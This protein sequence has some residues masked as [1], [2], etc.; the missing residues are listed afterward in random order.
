MGEAAPP[1]AGPH[2]RWLPT[3]VALGGITAAPAALA[4][5]IG[6]P[7]VAGLPVLA[8]TA[9]LSFAVQ[10]AAFVPSF[11]AQT[12]RF[13]DLTG[14]ATYVA[15]VAVCLAAGAAR[16]TLSPASWVVA[17]MVLAWSLRLGVFLFRRVHRD[18]GDRRF[19]AIKP[20]APR[21][22]T[23]WTLQGLWVWLTSLAAQVLILT[24]PGLGWAVG[25]GA[26]LWAVG[27]ALE[28]VADR[29]K[30][31][32]RTRP[33]RGPFIDSGLWAWSRHPNY[34]GEILLWAGVFVVGLGHWQGALWLTAL[35]PVFVYA[36]L[37][38]GSGVPLLEASADARWGDDPAYQAYKARTPVLWPGGRRG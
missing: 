35:S 30:S 29:Q 26:L 3:V 19:E 11:R 7:E 28:V 21:F 6:G 1:P 2:R 14:T 18:G 23:A 32:W 34:A 16:G 13:Y 36:L 10:W 4:F 8:W 38:H 24:G 25:C 27:W 12:E 31:A 15:V 5:A 17:L 33:D 37:R 22:L 9:G 20:S